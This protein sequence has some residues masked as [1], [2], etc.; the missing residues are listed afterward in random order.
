MLVIH[1]KRV[2]RLIACR[3]KNGSDVSR[4]YGLDHIK[5]FA[6]MVDN[7]ANR[8]VVAFRKLIDSPRVDLRFES[9]DRPNA[10]A[11]NVFAVACVVVFDFQC[12]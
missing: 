2:A 10:L 12:A 9:P 5:E 1:A 8:V 7:R 11:I 4:R 6:E 3:R